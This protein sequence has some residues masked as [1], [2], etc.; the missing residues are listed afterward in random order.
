LWFDPAG[1][2]TLTTRS[3]E[4][5][6]RVLEPVPD[7]A[8]DLTQWVVRI[9]ERRLPGGLSDDYR[10]SMTAEQFVRHWITFRPVEEHSALAALAENIKPVLAF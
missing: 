7:G 9:G 10:A 5:S 8:D 2:L 6:L 3:L 4:E 1:G